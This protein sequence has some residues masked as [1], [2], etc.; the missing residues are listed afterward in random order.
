LGAADP[1]V[2]GI[3]LLLGHLGAFMSVRSIS[4]ADKVTI[5][6]IRDLGLITIIIII[7]RW[8]LS[9]APRSF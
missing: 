9:A 8:G 7:L 6:T 1:P 2:A 5:I 3:P 4:M